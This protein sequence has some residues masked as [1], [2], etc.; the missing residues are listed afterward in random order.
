V[1]VLAFTPVFGCDFVNYD[2][3]DYAANN[4]NVQDGLSIR[5][6]AWAWNGVHAGNWHPLTWLS[7]MVDAQLFGTGPLGFHV[8]NLVLHL[9]NTLLLFVLLRQW[10]TDVW[11]SAFIAALF[12]VHPL[13]VESVAWVT[14]RKDVLSTFFGLLALLAYTRYAR[15]PCLIWYAAVAA[16]FTLSLLAKPMLVTLPFLLLLLDYW[17]FCRRQFPRWAIVEKLPLVAISAV[18]CVVT[19]WAQQRV[20]SSLV[21]VPFD[22]RLAN[23][24]VSYAQYLRQTILPIDLT[25]F[26]PHPVTGTSLAAAAGAASILLA[27]SATVY[28][29][30]R[31]L[32]YLLVGWLWF[33]GTL[34]PV[35][36]LFQV[37]GQARADRYTYFPLIG[38]FLGV[39]WGWAE[40]AKR[41]RCPRLAAAIAGLILLPLPILTW[42]Q[43]SCWRDSFALWSHALEVTDGNWLAYCNL[44][45]AWEDAGQF[46]EAVPYYEH[47]IR[48]SHPGNARLHSILGEHLLDQ[49][50]YGQAFRHFSAAMGL[51]H[52]K[53]YIYANLGQALR[54]LGQYT[55]SALA[56]RRAVRLEPDNAAFRRALAQVLWQDGYEQESYS[57]YEEA[58]RLDPDWLPSAQE[59]AWDL[60]TSNDR[61]LRNGQKA[62]QLGEQLRQA[63]MDHDARCL[64]ILAAAYAEHGDFAD[65]V[66][67]ARRAAALAVERGQTGLAKKIQDRLRMYERQEP[68]RQQS[69]RPTP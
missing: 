12:A 30:R 5:S 17:P 34:V 4:P 22:A 3:G 48:Y 24:L 9:A 11:P 23:A 29:L 45:Q 55:E 25:V 8:T 37:G 53:P 31:Q 52:R 27:I 20:M 28:A 14:E 26:Y 68:Y 42:R 50:E 66:A 60:A 10:T 47:A 19:I 43:T 49:G 40:L 58:L 38:I 32:P 62:V 18:F 2:D 61:N 46:A 65:A 39:A 59:T 35:I 69:A 54:G 6:F 7:L 36:G 13:H 41:L 51:G 15:A 67:T 1:T 21:L 63:T 33:L 64:D 56:L 57:E 44:G 16:C